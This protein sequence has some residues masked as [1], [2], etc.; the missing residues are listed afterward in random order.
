MFKLFD[1]DILSALDIPAKSGEKL[2]SPHRL[3]SNEN[4]L[5]SYL[6]TIFS[7]NLLAN[8]IENEDDL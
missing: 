5:F 8:L 1:R 2:R 4:F 7:F 6:K 3:R